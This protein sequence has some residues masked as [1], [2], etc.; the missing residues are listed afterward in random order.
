MSEKSHVGMAF[1]IC[2]ICGEKHSEAILLD[3]RMKNSLERENFMGYELCPEHKEMSKEFV[4]L[5]EVEEEPKQDAKLNEVKR[6]GGVAHFRRTVAAKVFDAEI[7]D[8]M[9]FVYVE[10]GMLDRLQSMVQP[11]DSEATPT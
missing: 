11:D 6:T 5:V 8:D 7:P 9:P 10:K 2:P 4:A 1:N 3:T